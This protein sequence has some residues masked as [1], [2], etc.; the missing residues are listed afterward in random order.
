MSEAR[1]GLRRLVDRATRSTAEIDGARLRRQ[2]TD[3]GCV[4][5]REVEPRSVATVEGEVRSVTLRPRSDVP[6]M[7]VE[8]WDGS[9]PLQL[10]WLGRRRI[11]GVEPGVRL[12]ATGRVSLHRGHATIY[13]PAYT[14]VSRT[15]GTHD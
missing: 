7:V 9:D 8:L 6:A 11:L 12:R 1:G 5:I 13:N 2:S 4:H 15:G 3:A 10:V 14:I